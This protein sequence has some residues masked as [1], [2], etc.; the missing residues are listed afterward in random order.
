MAAATGTY[1]RRGSCHP[2]MFVLT[3]GNGRQ[4]ARVIGNGRQR[5]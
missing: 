1:T 4:F 3:N 5:C 2:F